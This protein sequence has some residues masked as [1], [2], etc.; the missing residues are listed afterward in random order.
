MIASFDG[1]EAPLT[2]AIQGLI[3][4]EDPQDLA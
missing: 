1:D 3:D 2:A 4:D